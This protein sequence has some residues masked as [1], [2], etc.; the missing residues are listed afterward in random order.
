MVWILGVELVELVEKNMSVQTIQE[1]MGNETTDMKSIKVSEEV[2]NELSTR[3]HGGESFDEVLKRV[4]GLVPRTVEDL[5]TLLPERLSTA[6]ISI[7]KDYVNEEERY[8]RIGRR[9]G[10]KHTLKFVSRDSNNVIYEISVYLPDAERVN[11][12]VDIHSRSPQNQL[13]RTVQLRDV[14][15]NT[16]DISEY[17]AF[18]TRETKETTRRGDDAG[19]KAAEKVGPHVANFVEQA[20]DVWGTRS[21]TDPDV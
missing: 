11:H 14:E 9:D 6:I 20:Y 4:L 3:K 16:V 5:A 1:C 10:T 12:R 18:D 8:R 2:H 19:R 7:V 21:E 13:T 15:D 17:V